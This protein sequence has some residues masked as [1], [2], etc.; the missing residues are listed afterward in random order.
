MRA[1]P[2]LDKVALKINPNPLSPQVD[3]NFGEWFVDGNIFMKSGVT[4]DAR[5]EMPPWKEFVFFNDRMPLGDMR[6]CSP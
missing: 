2:A 1:S 5:Y 4:L 3:I 6:S